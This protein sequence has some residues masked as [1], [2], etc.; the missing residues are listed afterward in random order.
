MPTV[1]VR[2]DSGGTDNVPHAF[3]VL[4][5]E[6]GNE[7]GYGFAP[8]AHLNF[9]GPGKVDD[10]TEHEFDNSWTLQI[11]QQQFNDLESYVY[12]GSLKKSVVELRFG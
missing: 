5:D 12:F 1:E 10:N 9:W 7:H 6:L 4:T 3:I 8:A 11:T 2:I